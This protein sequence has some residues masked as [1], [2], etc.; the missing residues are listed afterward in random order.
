MMALTQK[1]V[2]DKAN[3]VYPMIGP[4]PPIAERNAY[5]R[6]YL[7]AIEDMNKMPDN[8]FE[9][10][11]EGLRSLWPAGDKKVIMPDGSAKTYA[12]RDS[13]SNLVKR[14]EFI[15]KDRHFR[16]RYSVEDCM[17]AARRYLAQYE[18]N[19]K[20]MQLLKYFVFKQGN[21]KNR[22]NKC[23]HVYESKFADML[24]SN[25]VTDTTV[26]YG[27]LFDSSNTFDQGELI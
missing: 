5:A 6:G 20:Y 12:W 14:L 25:P 24:E 22:N 23:T 18:D 9:Q 7:D 27:S 13:V 16:D 10:V 2:Y 19:T 4:D 3:R 17:M 8:F 15:W 26:D 11:A 21:L 1:E